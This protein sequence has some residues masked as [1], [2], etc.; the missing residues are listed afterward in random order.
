MKKLLKIPLVML[1]TLASILFLAF[2]WHVW[3]TKYY[4]P[5]GKG[6]WQSTSL[7]GRFT[8][9][10]YLIKGLPGFIPT[11]PGNGS[12]GSG[13]IVL[14]D[15]QTGKSLQK[16]VLIPSLLSME[17]RLDDEVYAC[18]CRRKNGT[19]KLAR[20]FPAMISTTLSSVTS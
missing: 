17:V 7:D 4:V 3:E 11:V 1:A 12:G 20:P 13:V 6:V 5:S 15:N 9:V 14:R 2:S 19:R 18:V 16:L 8:V 10:G